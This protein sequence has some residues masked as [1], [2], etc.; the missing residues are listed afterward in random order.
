[1]QSATKKKTVRL[2][3]AGLALVVGGLSLAPAA[4]AASS[5]A[6]RPHHKQLT[7]EQKTCLK[8]QGITKPEKGTR[9]TEEQREAFKAAA[10]S[11]GIELPTRPT[12]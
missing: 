5:S 1:M 3:L 10:E 4:G 2:G 12:A 7:D 11:C 8:G 6:S 9:P